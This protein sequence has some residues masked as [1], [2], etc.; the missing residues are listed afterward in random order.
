MRSYSFSMSIEFTNLKVSK[1]FGY[2][3][4]SHF[5]PRKAVADLKGPQMISYAGNSAMSFSKCCGVSS[6]V[7][8]NALGAFFK[9]SIW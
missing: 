1:A 8:A 5:L 4:T 3:G 2:S 6:N 9:H 7:V